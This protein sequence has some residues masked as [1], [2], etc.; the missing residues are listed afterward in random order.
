MKRVF[1]SLANGTICIFS[2][3]SISPDHGPQFGDACVNL[4][5]CSL[6]CEDQQ[7]FSEANDWA[8]PYIITLTEGFRAPA[9]KCMTFVGKDHLWC[10]CGNRISVMDVVNLKVE[11]T[12]EV[13]NRRTQHI[14]VLV[15]NGIKVWGIGRQLSCVMEWDAK[16][17]QLLT[18]FDCSHVDPTSN[19]LKGDPASIPELAIPDDKM[20]RDEEESPSA[21][22]QTINDRDDDIGND[23][24]TTSDGSP[25]E[26]SFEVH[27]EPQDPSKTVNAVF[28]PQLSRKTLKTFR[29][30]PRTRAYNITPQGKSIFSPRPEMDALRKAKVRSH[31]RQQGATR[32]TSLLLVDDT[33]WIA[34]GMGD[35]LMV[36]INED[37]NHG[38][39]MGRLASEDYNK[40]GNRSNHK[41]CLV[42]GEYVV[43]SQWLEPLDMQRPRAATVENSTARSSIEQPTITAHQQITIWEAWNMNNI[44]LYNQ[45]ISHMF[46][47]DSQQS[48]D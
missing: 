20:N 17:Y 22:P 47:L 23:S 34:R 27:N 24:L 12:F 29:K 9:V 8:D 38:V 46:Q 40:Y 4:E 32:T 44:K 11:S 48:D 41:V 3:K 42:G 39:V 15:S 10:G 5:A 31:L 33:L 16:T 18:I 26:Q 2:R 6:H 21:S 7:Y 28:H 43:S 14:N 25:K 13:F 35:V 36:N 45:K 19:C 1:A 30:P 37:E